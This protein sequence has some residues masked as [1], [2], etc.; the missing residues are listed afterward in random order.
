[1]LVKP[2]G[3]AKQYEP[4]WVHVPDGKTTDKGWLSLEAVE[5]HLA[6]VSGPVLSY[7][8]RENHEYNLP[9]QD[10]YPI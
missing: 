4:E 9:L 6:C 3:R 1:M 2:P 5:V 10:Y 7:D 8:E